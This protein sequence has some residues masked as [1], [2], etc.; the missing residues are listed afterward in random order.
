[1][2]LGPPPTIGRHRNG[3]GRMAYC[4]FIPEPP[5]TSLK[6][7]HKLGSAVLEEQEALLRRWRDQVRGL[8]SAKHLDLPTLNDHIAGW[9][10]TLAATLLALVETAAQTRASSPVAHGV[11]R[12]DDGFDI[13]EVVA[14]YNIMRDCVYDL[15]ERRGL[16]LRG[17]GRRAVDRVFDEAIGAAVKA[18]ATSQAQEVQRRRAEHLA[19]VAHDLRTPL[20][21]ITFAAG[22]LE[23][24]LPPGSLDADNLRVLKALRRNATQLDGLV[25][26]VL[27]ENAQLLTEFGVKV[28]RRVFDL[29]PMI[30]TLLQ[31]L[32]PLAAKS[33]TRL[34]NE[35]ADDLTLNADATLMRRILQNLVANAVGYAPGGEVRI[36]ARDPGDGQP[37]ECWVADNGA[38]I[39]AGRL[40]TVFDALETDPQRDGTGLGLAIVETFVEAHQGRVTVESI[41]GQ[42][43]T[44]RFTL[45]RAAVVAQPKDAA[46]PVTPATQPS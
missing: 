33:A 35:V 4:R 23:K 44:F 24:R 3:A 38:G 34:I 9:L 32:Q 12:F 13:E 7:L 19:F 31:D 5:D 11:Q 17:D 16:D 1:M 18:F 28:E 41:E 2:F 27:N 43:A 14:E 36:G 29:W 15:A 37:V 21:V 42:G 26:Q 22:I 6:S 8:V 30:E 39:P 25:A 45:P 40:A 20:G 10:G 46:Q